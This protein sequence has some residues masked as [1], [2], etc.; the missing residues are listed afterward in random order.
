MALLDMLDKDLIKVPLKAN[1][2]EGVL[3]ELV[4]LLRESGKISHSD[5]LLQGLLERESLGSTGLDKGIAVPHAKTDQVDNIC[6]V[7]GI[8]EKGVDFEALDGQNSHLFFMIISRPEQTSQHI[9]ALSEIAGISRTDLCT[10]LRSTKSPE[11]VMSL[12]QE[13]KK[14]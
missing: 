3:K 8:S 5:T 1:D 2:K 11:E 4:D 13:D 9:Q 6:I 14:E 12:F 7:L 10:R